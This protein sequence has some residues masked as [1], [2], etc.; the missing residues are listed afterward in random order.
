MI[1]A[2]DFDGTIVEHKFPEIGKEIPHAIDTLKFFQGLGHK[3]ILWTCR[4]KNYLVKAIDF[5][6][7]KGLYFDA[8]NENI[9]DLIE[10]SPRKI[11]ADMYVDDRSFP[12]FKLDM[13][14]ELKDYVIN[15][16]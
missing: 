11:F 1:I 14:L 3:I 13:W 4:E 7:D 9:E 8:I 10:Y 16:K 5:L 6:N 12:G 15:R 2:V